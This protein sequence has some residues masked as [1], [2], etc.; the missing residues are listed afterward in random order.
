MKGRHI[1]YSLEEREFVKENATL[2]RSELHKRF[3]E[4]FNRDDVAMTNLDALRKRNGWLTGRTGRFYKGQPKING[5]GAKCANKTSFKK[6]NKVWNEK[7][8]GAMRTA[9]D[10]ILEIKTGHNEWR[11]YHRVIYEQYHGSIPENYNVTFRDGDNRNF[12][13]A[14]LQAVSNLELFIKNS[15][16]RKIPEQFK[17]SKAAEVLCDLKVALHQAQ[18]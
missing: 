10:D 18:N 1:R 16:R 8:I 15:T 13:K 6:G 17:Y 4:R 3:V 11:P 2:V 14:N 9:K 5:S 12:D 7:P